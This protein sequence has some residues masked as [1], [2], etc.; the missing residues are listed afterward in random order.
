M[1]IQ[2]L[3]YVLAALEHGSISAAAQALRLAQPSLS[4][5]IRALEGELGVALFA[6]TSRG[7]VATEAMRAM[8]PHAERVLAEVD[9]LRDSVAAVREVRGGTV[10]FG[11]FGFA[12]DYLLGDLVAEMRAR[13]P[14]VRVRLVGRNSADVADGVRSGALEAGL[15]VLPVDDSGLDVRPVFREEVLY[16]SADPSRVAR[17]VTMAD[18]AVAPLILCDAGYA[19]RDPLRLQVAARAQEA[20][21]MLT[22]VIEVEDLWTALDLAARGLGDTIVGAAVTLRRGFP[23]R[24]GTVGFAEP[25][26][27]VIA[28]VGRRGAPLSPATRALVG[29]AERRLEEL[30]GRM[31][32]A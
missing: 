9:A 18:L 29:L 17:P 24:L 14:E 10:S 27:D 19:N 3:R 25:L 31:R 21:I 22:P 8:R 16:A 23:R 2:Q 15:V 6:R 28:V 11:T 1:T 7:L 5:Q 12:G 4:E 26:Q 13:H 30:A 32:G 20:G